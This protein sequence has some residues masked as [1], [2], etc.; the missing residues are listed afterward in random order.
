MS[1][2]KVGRTKL[3]ANMVH[4]IEEVAYKRGFNDGVRAA[5]KAVKGLRPAPQRDSE[6]GNGADVL[7]APQPTRQLRENSDQMKVLNAIRAKPGM[8][9]VEILSWLEAQGTKVHERTLRTALARL[10]NNF[11][12]QREERWY[13][14]RPA[15]H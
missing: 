9:G 10:K 4:E 3:L 7:A 12:E 13:E 11:I 14:M 8:R 6:A 5:M 15:G 2:L 1:G